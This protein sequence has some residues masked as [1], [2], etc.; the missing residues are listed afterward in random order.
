MKKIISC[1]VLVFL[2]TNQ[3]MA[4][5][6][7]QLTRDSRAAVKALGSE[8]KAT[9]QAAVKND[10][11]IEA[12]SVCNTK[13][14]QISER[15]SR[16]KGLS[17]ART[18]LKYRNQGNKPDA[19]EKNVLQQFEQRKTQGEAV[20]TLEFSELTELE[21][22]KVFRYMKAIPTGEVCLGCHG[23]NMSP[24]ISDRINSLYPDDKATG[25]NKGDIRGA[26]TIIKPVE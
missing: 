16:E 9:L 3:A 5:D 23:S 22:K 15:I 7:E 19:W 10:G 24:E 13:A 4:A 25:F 14:P 6:T 26:F 11:A 8:L 1:F 12:I 20:D 21:G 17:V 18:S 2:A